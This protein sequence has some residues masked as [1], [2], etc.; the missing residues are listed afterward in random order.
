MLL[1]IA[2]L[3]QKPKFGV[4][5][6]I[7]NGTNSIRGL[8]NMSKYLIGDGIFIIKEEDDRIIITLCA[9]MKQKEQ[10]IIRLLDGGKNT[11]IRIHNIGYTY[12]ETCKEE[13]RMMSSRAEV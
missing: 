10:E 6:I 11:E 12:G 1:D 7:A 5:I 9:W 2:V 4:N 13:I 8:L 3:L